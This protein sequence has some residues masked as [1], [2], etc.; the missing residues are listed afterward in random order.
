V[1][2]GRGAAETGDTGNTTKLRLARIPM[3]SV[4]AANA[5]VT[6]LVAVRGIKLI[7]IVPSRSSSYVKLP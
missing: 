6:R 3:P 7:K 4:V 1:T 5:R 2:V